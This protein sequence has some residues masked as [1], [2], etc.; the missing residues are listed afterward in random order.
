MTTTF[1]GERQSTKMKIQY[2]KAA[3]KQDI[4]FFDTE[5]RTSEVVF[6]INTDVVMVQ[7][8]IS[9]KLGNFIHYMATFVS[10]I[11]VGFTAVWKLALVTLAVVPMIAVTGG[12]HTTMVDPSSTSNTTFDDF[13]TMRDKDFQH[14]QD[15]MVGNLSS[16]QDG[17][18]QITSANL[19]K[20]DA[21]LCEITQAVSSSSHV[22]FDES[23]FLQ[24]N[25][26]WKQVA[27]PIRTYTNVQKAGSVGR[28]IDVTTFK[29]YQEL[30]RAIECMFRLNGLLN[31]TK[32]QNGES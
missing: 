30:I 29:N 3:L 16:S 6:A 28:S 5:V 15:C 11:L 17:Q 31:D 10:G 26:S 2:L 19:A 27:A 21:F 8:A 18:S 32:V 7:D 24:N 22:D 14:S 12:I 13:R 23:S 25:N 4:Q 1:T 9:E 20:L